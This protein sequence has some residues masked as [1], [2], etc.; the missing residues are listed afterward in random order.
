MATLAQLRKR[1]VLTEGRLHWQLARVHRERL[2]LE[3]HYLYQ[4]TPF[5]AAAF[6]VGWLS[7]FWVSPALLV[8]GGLRLAAREVRRFG[9][10]TLRRALF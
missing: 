3:A 8:G 6:G 1:V 9:R 2:L 7:A 5:L 4:P 10:H